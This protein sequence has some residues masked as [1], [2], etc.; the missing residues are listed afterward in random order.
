MVALDPLLKVLGH[1]VHRRAR[2]KTDPSGCRDGRPIGT[3]R[4]RAD[5]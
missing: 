4:V 2:Q 3:G 1:V 5:P